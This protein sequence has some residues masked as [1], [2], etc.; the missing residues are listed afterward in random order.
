MKC[1]YRGWIIDAAPDSSCGKFFAHVRLVRASTDEETEGEMHIERHLAWFDT[2]EEAIE[3]A[4]Q[5]AFAWIN[6]RD[7]EFAG[8]QDES[9]ISRIETPIDSVAR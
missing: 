3:V 9:Q 4:Q 1:G 8:K 6:T 7:G 2:E 5:W